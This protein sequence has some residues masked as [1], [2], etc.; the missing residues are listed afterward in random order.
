MVTT[1]D[2]IHTL[3]VNHMAFANKLAHERK[4]I[5]PRCIDFEE[6]QSAAY[7]GL[8][9][10]A[11][12]YRPELGAFT[13]YAWYRVMG[14]IDD[15]LR[16]LGRFGQSLDQE[17]EG[18]GCRK[19][20]VQAKDEPQTVE[21]IEFLTHALDDERADKIIDLYFV[22]NYSMKEIAVKFGVSESRVS[23]LIAGY[24]ETI[25]STWSE[26]ELRM[27]LAA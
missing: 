1:V 19:D 21:V 8:V 15:Y 16:S 3:T 20:L 10:A 23:Q 9:Q 27:T 18:G 2:E 11:N 26:A 7:L 5:L 14:A 24:R 22:Q 6:L 4:R 12:R 25:R 17:T 13:T